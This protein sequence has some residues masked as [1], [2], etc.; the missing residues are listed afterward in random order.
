[1]NVFQQIWQNF[2]TYAGRY[3]SPEAARKN[4]VQ[5][6]EL[7]QAV[8]KRLEK[9]LPKNV[10]VR[11]VTAPVFLYYTEAAGGYGVDTHSG[12]VQSYR[13]VIAPEAKFEEQVDAAVEQL[14]ELIRGSATVFFYMPIYPIDDEGHMFVRMAKTGWTVDLGHQLTDINT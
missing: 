2:E 12:C 3:H 8:F 10:K 9:I 6:N 11:S 7:N 1:M 13:I 4:H 5:L 14:D